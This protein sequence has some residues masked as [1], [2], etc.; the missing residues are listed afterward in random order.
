MRLHNPWGRN[1]IFACAVCDWACVPPAQAERNNK[2][3]K[4][5]KNNGL[6]PTGA[7]GCFA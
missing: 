2:S 3:C 1:P 4:R 7:N 5:S 6:A